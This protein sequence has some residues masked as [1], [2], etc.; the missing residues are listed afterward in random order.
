[1]ERQI[2]QFGQWSTPSFLPLNNMKKMFDRADF[3]NKR[4]KTKF[5]CLFKDTRN[6]IITKSNKT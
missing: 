1:M 2:D 3:P 4:I 5:F 6:K